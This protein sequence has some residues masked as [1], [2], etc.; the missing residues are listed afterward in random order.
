MKKKK[1]K[2]SVQKKLKKIK[3]KLKMLDH[4]LHFCVKIKEICISLYAKAKKFLNILKY[5]M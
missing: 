1:I 4:I 5:L 3:Q 2:N